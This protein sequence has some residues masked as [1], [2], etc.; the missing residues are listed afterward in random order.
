MAAGMTI[1]G[2]AILNGRL[3]EAEVLDELRQLGDSA[4]GLY[5]ALFVYEHDDNGTTKK[6]TFFTADAAYAEMLTKEAGRV[7]LDPEMLRTKFPAY[8]PDWVITTGS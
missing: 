1:I 7:E 6:F 5:G 4:D 2:Y 3:I 8:Q